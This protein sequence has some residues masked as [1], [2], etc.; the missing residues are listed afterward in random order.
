MSG[1]VMVF[2]GLGA[3]WLVEQ[4]GQVPSRV[5]VES[6]SGPSAQNPGVH[7]PYHGHLQIR[8]PVLVHP[9]AKEPSGS[10]L[11][12][13]RLSARSA[14]PWRTPVSRSQPSSTA[15]AFSKPS[16]HAL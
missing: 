13:S 3:E 9:P 8:I 6:A 5:L 4:P 15:T 10:S 11:Q 16:S 1:Q 12:P 14:A 2:D 7:S